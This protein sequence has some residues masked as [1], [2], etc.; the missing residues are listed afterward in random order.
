MTKRRDIKTAAV[1]TALLLV[2]GSAAVSTTQAVAAAKAPSGL[3]ASAV[4]ARAIA[5]TWNKAGDDTYRVRIADNPSMSN[6][7]TRD[8]IGNYFE[9]SRTSPDPNSTAPRLTPGATYYFQV[10]AIKE[11]ISTAARSDLTSYSSAVAVTT[12]TGDDAELPPVE[13]KATNGGA[14]SMYLSW[15]TRG[16]GLRYLLRYTTNPSTNIL[17]WSAKQ[18]NAAGGTLTGLQPG[19]QYHFRVRV[20][21]ANGQPLSD[22]SETWSQQ[23][24]ARTTSP[25][26]VVVSYNIHKPTGSPSWASR[27]A[28]VAASVKEQNPN[29]V[30]LQ[31]ATPVTVTNAKGKKVRQYQDILS[32]IGS[33]YA[34]VTTK[35]SS[36][37]KLAY[38]KTRF[39]MAKASAVKLYTLGSSP[40]YAVWA[41]LKDR[42]SGKKFF[43][44]NTHLEPGSNTSA[45]HN[46]ARI[47]QAKQ[48]LSLITKYNPKKWPVVVAGD[49]NSSRSAKPTN[50]PYLTLTNAGLV[51]LLDNAV[52]SWAS[53]E[54]AVVEHAV[55][56]EY[57]S[58]NGYESLARRTGYPV[59]T[60]VDYILTSK[61]IRAAVWRTVVDLDANRKFVGT[62]PSDHNL[63]TATLHLP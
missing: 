17:N 10:K 22:Y 27:R 55:D 41:V 7:Q 51:D 2:A 31:E 50:G 6:P 61:S 19:T 5:L 48:V 57:N 32:L 36:G 4:S 23:T 14:N 63:V 35:G 54:N 46:D 37:T 18:F 58:F 30:A 15:R 13:L 56:V 45:A 49:L 9:L 8:V 47:K 44:L 26:I 60:N 25:G 28:K 29:V 11:A 62:M 33:K 3:R 1:A 38:D 59:G 39:I 42:V 34:L 20:I 16:P 12:D 24:A 52:G 43:V 40:R 21:D 53:G